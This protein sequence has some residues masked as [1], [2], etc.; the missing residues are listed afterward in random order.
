MTPVISAERRLGVSLRAREPS[1]A[2][3]GGPRKRI[4]SRVTVAAI[5]SSSSM[6]AC[7]PSSGRA[8]ST[9]GQRR[10]TSTV[11]APAGA[12]ARTPSGSSPQASQTIRAISAT[13]S[14]REAE[15]LKSSF[16]PA[17]EL[18]AATMPSAMSSTWVSV[19]VCSPEPKICSGRWPAST[20]AIRSGTAWAMPGARVGHLARA[21]RVERSADRERQAVLVVR[22]AAVDLAGRASRSRTRSSGTRAS[23][24]G[25]PRGSGT[26]P[27]ARTPSRRRRRRSRSTS[28]S[29][30]ARM[31]EL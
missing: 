7:Q 15:M 4:A 23:A 20:F 16:S 14:S 24:G 17:G 22:G 11:E 31:T 1:R 3:G 8:F 13:V 30:A 5:P 6:R 21:V 19:R 26:A 28:S 27:P 12:R 18:I 29:S 9:D 10:C 25:G 2:A